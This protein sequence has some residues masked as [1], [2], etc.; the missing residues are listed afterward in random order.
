MKAFNNVSGRILNLTLI[1]VLTL[2]RTEKPLTTCPDGSSR[3]W[4]IPIA[5]FCALGA[6][7]HFLLPIHEY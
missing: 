6:R 2:A 1:P 7:K 5:R 4:L 3:V